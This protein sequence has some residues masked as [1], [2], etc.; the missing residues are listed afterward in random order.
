MKENEFNQLSP[1]RNEALQSALHLWDGVSKE[2]EVLYG[3]LVDGK[4]EQA[5]VRLRDYAAVHSGQYRALLLNRLVILALDGVG[6]N[7][8]EEPWKEPGESVVK[9]ST[10][11]SVGPL[12][13]S[14]VGKVVERAAAG[15][16][17]AMK[18]AGKAPAERKKTATKVTRKRKGSKSYGGI[19]CDICYARVHQS[20]KGQ[21]IVKAHPEWGIT[22]E[23]MPADERRAQ[24][25]HLY[26]CGFCGR[27]DACPSFLVGHVRTVHPEM[28]LPIL[29][30]TKERL[31]QEVRE[32]EV[33]SVVEA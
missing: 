17:R 31:M 20:K 15:M 11:A 21:H 22:E 18:E 23:W 19:Y 29:E 13:G 27:V 16:A 14:M 33:K 5:A 7:E 9:L 1:R 30:C 32:E 2:Q 10:G 25:R 3:L 4:S 24:G 26:T 6:T 28:M 12:A 8:E